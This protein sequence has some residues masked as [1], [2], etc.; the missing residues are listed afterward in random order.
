MNDSDINKKNEDSGKDAG[1]V[2]SAEQKKAL[3]TAAKIDGAL[4][5]LRSTAIT[6]DYFTGY[7]LNEILQERLDLIGEIND[8]TDSTVS[9]GT[10]LTMVAAL[11]QLL[12]ELV[13]EGPKHDGGAVKEALELSIE[14]ISDPEEK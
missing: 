9:D 2:P 6:N 10:K 4:S 7:S 11:N 3:N 5:F 14:N 12:V 13:G 1:Y 8:K